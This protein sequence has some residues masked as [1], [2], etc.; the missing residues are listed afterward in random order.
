VLAFGM[1]QQGILIGS[2]HWVVRVLHLAVGLAA[3]PVAER[4]VAGPQSAPVRA[5]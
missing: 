5:A 2:L 3:L 4:L 1:T